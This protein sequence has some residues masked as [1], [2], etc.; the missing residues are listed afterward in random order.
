MKN[1]FQLAIPLLTLLIGSAGGYFLG[2]EKNQ[3]HSPNNPNASELTARSSA[4]AGDSSEVSAKGNHRKNESL[5]S[6]LTMPSQMQRVQAMMDFYAKLSPAEL[7]DEARKLESLPMPERI[8]ASYLLFA[9]WA[10]TDPLSAL[11]FSDKLGFTGMFA[12]PTIMQSWASVDPVNA[13]KFYQENPGQFAMMGMFGGRGGR[14][15]MGG[16]AASIIAGEWAKQDPSAA[17]AWAKQLNSGEKG[18]AINSIIQQVAQMDSDKA[19]TLSASLE[20]EEKQRAHQQIAEA[21]GQNWDKALS[22]IATLPVDEQAEAKRKAF[23]GLSKTNP[24]RALTELNGFADGEARNQATRTVLGELSKEQPQQAFDYI[25]SAGVD[26]N[27][28]SIRPV[29]MNYARQ[30]SQGAAKAISKLPEGDTRD[31]AITTY[32]FASTSTDY[33]SGFAL[34]ESIGNDDERQRAL[35]VTSAKWMTSNPEAAKAAINQSTSLN[36][37]QKARLLENPRDGMR[38]GRGFRND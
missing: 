19:I 36:E 38:F 24:E 12:K 1:N 5:A 14:G 37:E 30:D 26:K 8:M 35:A 20:G 16:S 31:N 23:E 10:E 21:L 27:A 3:A 7:E 28:E 9:K 11:A 29:M 18:N 32:A 22:Y 17:M 33:A 4:R 34:A 15:P 6:I 2:Q 13:A 25:I